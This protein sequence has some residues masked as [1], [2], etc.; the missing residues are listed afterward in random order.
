M[1]VKIGGKDAREGKLRKKCYEGYMP[2][3]LNYVRKNHKN[4]LLNPIE[5]NQKLH[6]FFGV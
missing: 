1:L 3:A 2:N 5:V 6:A 4:L